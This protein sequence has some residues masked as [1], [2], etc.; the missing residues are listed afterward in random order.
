MT[1]ALILLT[2]VSLFVGLFPRF[3]VSSINSAFDLTIY[4]ASSSHYTLKAMTIV[5][6]TLLPF[7]LAYQA[8]SYFVFHKRL[9][10]KDHLEY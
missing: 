2:F 8:W 7:V 10:E 9:S 6:A 4:N 3:M 1:G 5:A